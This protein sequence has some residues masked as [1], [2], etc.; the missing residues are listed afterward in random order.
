VIIKPITVRLVA[1]G[2]KANVAAIRTR[3]AD[4]LK[5]EHG[6]AFVPDIA[7][8]SA[9]D[10]HAEIVAKRLDQEV[11]LK[12][13]SPSRV[14]LRLVLP[15]MNERLTVE[16]LHELPVAKTCVAFATWTSEREGVAWQLLMADGGRW[17]ESRPLG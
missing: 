13:P 4:L 7:E 3:A 6:K 14:G 9:A 11:V 16:W 17:S 2:Q 12:K 15:E 8:P 1:Y 5:E 10:A